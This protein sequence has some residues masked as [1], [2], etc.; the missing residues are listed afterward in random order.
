M[1]QDAVRRDVGDSVTFIQ[2]RLPGIA[3][4]WVISG[5]RMKH[6]PLLESP[7]FKLFV[8]RSSRASHQGVEEPQA[9]F[10]LSLPQGPVASLRA[11]EHVHGREVTIAVRNGVSN[12]H[13]FVE[14]LS[15]LGGGQ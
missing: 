15:N 9:L 10:H 13:P 1:L 4:P 2:A 14:L 7:P 3:D 6:P 5:Y 12:L 11:V 8:S